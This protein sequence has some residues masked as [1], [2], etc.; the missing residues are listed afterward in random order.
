MFFI[1]G[2]DGKVQQAG[3]AEALCPQCGRRG[4]FV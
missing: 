1:M 3:T 2:T 4:T